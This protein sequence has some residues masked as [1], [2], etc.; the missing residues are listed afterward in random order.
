MY[1]QE[2]LMEFV[3][4]IITSVI[5]CMLFYW[6]IGLRADERK[7]VADYISNKINRLRN[8]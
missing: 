1:M 5:S 2:G 6:I 3:L 8:K 7:F 4:T